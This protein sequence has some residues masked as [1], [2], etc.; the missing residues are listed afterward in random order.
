MKSKTYEMDMCSGPLLGKILMFALP[1]MMSSILQLLFNAADIIVVG[2]FVGHEA[3]AAVGATGPL[4]NLLINVFIGFSVGTN[5]MVAQFMGAGNKKDVSEVV[6]TSVMF[7]IICGTALIFLGNFFAEP[8]LRLMGTPEDVIGGAALYMRVYFS[9]MPIIMLYNFGSAIFRAIGDTKRP[10]YY[11]TAA[12]IVNVILNVI[13]VTQL[14]MGVEGVA[15]ATVLSQVLSAALVVRSLMKSDG[16]YKL[17]IK[18]LR[19]HKRKLK[20]IVKIGL[21]AGMQGAVFSISNVLIQSSINLFGSVAMAGSTAA[22]NIEGFVY[23]AMNAFHQTALSFT[24]QNYG[25]RNLDRI[26]RI[27]WL[28]LACV[29]GTGLIMGVSAWAFGNT[30]LRIYS[31]DPDV[32]ASGMIRLAGICLP[33]FLCGIMDVMVGCLRGVGYSFVPML[34]S[35]GGAC[36]LRIVWIFTVFRMYRTLPVLYASYPVTWGITGLCHFICF[37]IIFKKIKKSLS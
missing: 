12:G 16:A 26:K 14:H 9:G 7:S 8:M 35:V 33:Y 11:L 18:K 15:F 5:V 32:I 29:V 24:S 34:V 25:S 21:P 37:W 4:T 10:L 19:I 1:L 36:G 6:H 27:M 13:F 22:A 3:L 2:R 20:Y 23:M 28:C 17:E 30:L 31:S